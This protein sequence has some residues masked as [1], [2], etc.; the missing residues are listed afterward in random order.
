MAVFKRA[1]SLVLINMPLINLLTLKQALT[2]GANELPES[3]SPDLDC[4]LILLHAIG[5]H[6]N[7][8]FTDPDTLL[9][10]SQQAAFI[11]LI[12][13]RK[14]GEPVAYII[15]S[16][17]FWDLQ[18]KVAPHTLI[19]RG[20]TESIIDWVLDNNLQ[21]KRI[22]D[23]G[24]GTGALA[25]ALASEFPDAQVVGVDLIPQAVELANE[26]KALNSIANVVFKQSDWFDALASE[27]AFDLIVSNPPYIDEEDVHLDQ[28]D[29]RFEPSSALVSKQQG[30]AD[31]F[32]IATQA[33][34][35]LSKNGYLLMEH[36]W[37]Q[38]KEMREKLLELNYENVATGQDLASRD[39]FTYGQA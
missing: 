37:T 24:T 17:G 22:L 23:L 34:K 16:Q 13:R 21:P 5:Q 27:E 20:D 2:L 35:Y 38:G 10:A 19:P 29:V 15:G 39:R 11:E 9:D 30:F 3:D 6:R 25:L 18:L 28:G 31:L 32:H 12:A 8:L 36:G 33:K 26:N 14:Q 7:I 4:E 1:K